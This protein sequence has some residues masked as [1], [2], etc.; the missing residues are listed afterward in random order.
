MPKPQACSAL[1]RMTDVPRGH[2]QKGPRNLLGTKGG[3]CAGKPTGPEGTEDGLRHTASMEGLLASPQDKDP[4][5]SPL[6]NPLRST[7]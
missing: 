6:S 3:Q 4:L 5:L 1:S 2:K 7:A